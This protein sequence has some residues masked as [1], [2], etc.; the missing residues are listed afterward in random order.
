MELYIVLAIA[1]FM[2]IMFLW[3]KYPFGVVTMS[4]CVLLVL[5]GIQ[6]VSKAFSGFCNQ[7]VVL[8]APMLALSNALTKTSLVSMIRSKMDIM[9]GKSG[10][11]LVLFFFIIGAAFVQFIPATA[12]LSIMIVFL[13]TLSDT[14]EVTPGRI[15]LPL[16]GITCIWKSR[17]PIGM[18]ATTFARYNALY[19]G[20]IQNEAYLLKMMD[21]VMVAILPTIFL[22]VYCIFA[23][24]L[25]PK[26]TGINDNELKDVKETKAIPKYQEN[27]IY[28]V[29]VVV[30]LVLVFNKFTGK[31]MY[32]APA[33]GV[34]VLIYTKVLTVPEAVKSMTADM[35]WMIAG[36]LMVADALG[37]SGAGDL[38]GNA[39]LGVL[40]ENPSSLFV[41]LLF[42][43]ASV[44]MTTFLS[45]NACLNVLTPVAASVALAGGWDP[46]GIICIIAITNTLAIGF[47]SG[48]AECAVAYAAGGYNPG[49][50][51]KFTVPYMVIAI[52]TTA[53]SANLLF[54]IYG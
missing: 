44:V 39:I 17:L 52:V 9:K 31:L 26:G 10:L 45:N 22:T 30:M 14:G 24:K 3:Q 49:K 50:V 53:V 8:I 2:V 13:A 6:D 5:F 32:I 23:W 4:C 7:T 46:R 29:F 43:A 34:L 41:M 18:G 27:L 21:P 11:L 20:I 16:L 15:L 1:A 37:S 28:A 35:V 12:T 25:L 48:A 33:A 40:G 47:P 42:A 38:I 36:V 54:P 51:L 19:E